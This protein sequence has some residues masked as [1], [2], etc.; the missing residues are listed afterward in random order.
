MN[1]Y[2][3]WY[4]TIY[5]IYKRFSL[6]KHFDIFAT[7][8]FSLFVN[9]LFIG[10]LGFVLYWCNMQG[11]L[12]D[13]AIRFITPIMIVFIINCILFLPKSRQ[14]SWYSLYKEQQSAK[15]DVITIIICVFSIVVMILYGI[16]AHY[17]LNR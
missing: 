13:S 10:I 6:D 1:W 9:C 14:L 16:K 12:L 17:Y 11:L 15:R 2:F 3:Y 4:F 7:S 8:M 5:S